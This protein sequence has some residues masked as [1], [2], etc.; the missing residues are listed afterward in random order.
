MSKRSYN[1]FFNTHTVSGIVISIGLYVIFLAGAFALFMHNIDDWEKNKSH[2]GTHPVVDYDKVLD[3]VERE[4]YTMHGRDFR[5]YLYNDLIYVSS[6]PLKKKEANKNL[7]GALPD[8][9]A[10]S[11]FRLK[12][13]KESY[14]IVTNEKKAENTVGG[15]LF[16][17]HYF[18]Q[19]PVAGS[20]LAGLVA[21]FFLFASI[22]GLIVHWNKIFSNFFTFRLKASIKNL[23][24]DAHTSLGV[25]GFPFQ[26]M[27]AVTGAIFCIMILIYVPFSQVYY[28]GDNDAMFEEVYPSYR[29]KNFEI[30]G[31]TEDLLS[32]NQLSKKALTGISREKI[33]FVD[34]FIKNYK[35]VNAYFSTTIHTNI[36]HGFLNH[37]HE[38]RSLLD[39]HLIDSKEINEAPVYA[40][41]VVDFVHKIHFATYGG[42][43]TKI[44][45]FFLALLT[46]V[47]IVSGVL[48]WVK[49]RDNKKYSHRHIF[50][51]NV[52]AIYLGSC[53]GL[54]PAIAFLFLLAK[55]FPLEL[56]NRFSWIGWLFFIFWLM[57]TIYGYKIKSTFIINRNALF[58][59]GVMGMAI[60]IFNGLQ[61]GLWL[62]KSYG[63]GY[64]NSF[65]VDLGWLLIGGL[66][67]YISFRIKPP[68]AK[69]AHK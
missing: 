19:I 8:S 48:I 28:D 46:C 42:Y 16:D 15:F 5:I 6:K 66:T 11:G 20:Y 51:R 9:V 37:K 23:W 62:W 18:N 68:E 32:V 64:V 29:S 54:Y 17:L 41:A 52:G 44:I 4:G 31:Y 69:Q 36:E 14:T 2:E 40:K 21:F 12:L 13:D 35:D 67:L 61:S 53:L 50:N 27:Y 26:L 58:I 34:A 1:V 60:P 39:G 22:T 38:A 49:A 30:H 33:E 56:E 57:Y 25:I 65:F 10:N 55:V 59:G 3:K 63:Q 45:Y 43:F 24:T 47:V 7:N